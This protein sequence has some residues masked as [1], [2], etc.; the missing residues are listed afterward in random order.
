MYRYMYRYININIEKKPA[1]Q[2][3]TKRLCWIHI[4]WKKSL[5]EKD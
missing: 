3:I 1:L 2:K 4:T 5:W